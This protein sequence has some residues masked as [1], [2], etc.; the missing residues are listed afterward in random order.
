MDQ[1]QANER[2]R[3]AAEP[4]KK[5]RI[6]IWYFVLLGILSVALTGFLIAFNL[7]QQ[8]TLE[9]LH[10]ARRLWEEKGPKDYDMTYKKIM[11]RSEVF[12]VKV[13]GGNVVSVTLDGRPISGDLKYHSMRALFGYI[14]RFLEM[15]AKPNS[16]RTYT[17]ATFDE[18]DGHLRRYIRSVTATRHRV[19]IVVDLKPVRVTGSEA[20]K[21]AS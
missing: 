4:I 14:E 19:E 13:R 15:D 16:P 10:R 2:P 18:E 21:S 12:E 5:N 8:L 6:W 9:D 3:D 20:K 1:Q 7:K 17:V 11:E